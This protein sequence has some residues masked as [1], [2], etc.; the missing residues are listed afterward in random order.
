MRNRAPDF[1]HSADILFSN[2][3]AM[4]AIDIPPAALEKT[5]SP[6]CATDESLL[7]HYSECMIADG[8]LWRK[9]AFMLNTA[10]EFIHWW[11]KHYVGD[12]CR[13]F[14]IVDNRPADESVWWDLRETYL[15][16]A[17]P[18]HQLRVVER[19][20][21]NRFLRFIAAFAEC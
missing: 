6:S 4:K 17:C 21:L 20:G 19:A 3:A 8:L 7:K 12:E 14:T 18:D 13:I 15:R 2:G 9:R 5:S 1:G 10:Q 11:R 16:N